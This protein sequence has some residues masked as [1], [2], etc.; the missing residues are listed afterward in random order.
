VK[1]LLVVSLVV[2]TGGLLLSGWGLVMAWHKIT[3]KSFFGPRVA[4]WL[5]RLGSMARTITRR[6]PQP[7]EVRGSATMT[8]N[9]DMRAAGYPTHPNR[10]VADRLANLERGQGLLQSDVAGI[11]RD[12]DKALTATT[13]ALRAD[14]EN[15]SVSW[16]QH[17]NVRDVKQLRPAIWGLGVALIGVLLQLVAAV[18]AA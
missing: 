9:T 5:A 1:C 13:A 17:L 4:R 3:G 18:W 14:I 2:E 11:K 8:I 12:I 6:H 7:S 10:P 15:A 16:E